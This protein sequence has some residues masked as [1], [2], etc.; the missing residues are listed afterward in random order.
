M[1]LPLFM[2]NFTRCSSVLGLGLPYTWG[3]ELRR[4][5]AAGHYPDLVRH[6]E[7][8]NKI[9]TRPRAAR[10]ALHVRSGESSMRCRSKTSS[11][12]R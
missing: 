6:V 11:T 8:W 10:D 12:C 5:I 4:S 1:T 2:T 3:D 7:E 9:A